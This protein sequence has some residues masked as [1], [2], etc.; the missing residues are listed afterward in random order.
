MSRPKAIL[1]R[2]GPTAIVRDVD[3]DEVEPPWPK[4]AQERRQGSL[5]RGGVPR[6]AG[7][8]ATWPAVAKRASFASPTRC[9]L[10]TD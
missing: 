5:H 1:R 7:A 6:D 10:A 2:L 3:M 9:L 8:P 4:P